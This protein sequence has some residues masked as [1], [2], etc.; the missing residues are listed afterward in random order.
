MI[1]STPTTIIEVE[2]DLNTKMF[3]PSGGTCVMR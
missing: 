1:A 3:L 2:V